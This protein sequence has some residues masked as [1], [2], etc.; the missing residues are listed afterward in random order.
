MDFL[1]QQRQK[2][3][4]ELP[5]EGNRPEHR[6]HPVQGCRQ[7]PP[8]H[9]GAVR[10]TVRHPVPAG[11][12]RGFARAA[13]HQQPRRQQQDAGRGKRRAIPQPVGHESAD[14][15]TGHGARK[16]RRA[17]PAHGQSAPFMRHF[18]RQKG[19]RRRHRARQRPLQ[20]AEHNQHDR[21][22]HAP[23]QRHHHRPRQI[24]AYQHHALAVPVRQQ[25]P[26]RRRQPHGHRRRGREQRHPQLQFPVPNDAQLLLQK[27][28]RK[29][30]RKRKTHNG[31][32]LR[33]PYQRHL[34]F[35]GVGHTGAGI[36]P[37]SGRVGKPAAAVHP[38][39]SCAG[40]T[41]LLFCPPLCLP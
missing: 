5:H 23:H 20:Q 37:V 18:P 4:V 2:G 3:H 30:Q 8:V 16:D 12:P 9:P 31:Q 38:L 26:Q 13:Q 7:I 39:R 36:L 25:A 14:G 22:L 32:E 41:F 17:Q 6:Q 11:G 24:R 33:R 1:H 29:R 15:Y 28:G 19:L 21:R 27:I 10:R 40:G 34:L 35:P